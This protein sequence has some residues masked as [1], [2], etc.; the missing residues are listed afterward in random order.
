MSRSTLETEGKAQI[1]PQIVLFNQQIW[2]EKEAKQFL[3]PIRLKDDVL[4]QELGGQK[5]VKNDDVLKFVAQRIRF[6]YQN[7]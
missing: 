5:Q 7:F 6:H 2:S 4:A 3:S 1:R